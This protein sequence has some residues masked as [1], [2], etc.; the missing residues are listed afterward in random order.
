MRS[1][2]LAFVVMCAG[3]VGLV[4]TTQLLTALPA[5]GPTA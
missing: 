5:P 4:W 3:G 2:V 1:M